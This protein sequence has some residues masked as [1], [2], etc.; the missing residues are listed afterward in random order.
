MISYLFKT[1]TNPYHLRHPEKKVDLENLSLK[2]RILG[3]SLF[4]LSGFATL[5]IL[6]A[7]Y[8][9]KAYKKITQKSST[10]TMNIQNTIFSAQKPP[11]SPHSI[12]NISRMEYESR[13]HESGVE[14]LQR[15]WIKPKRPLPSIPS[16]PNLVNLKTYKAYVH[17]YIAEYCQSASRE[18]FW[19]ELE[20][21]LRKSAAPDFD[22]ERRLKKIQNSAFH[23]Y[24]YEVLRKKYQERDT[25]TDQGDLQ[26]KAMKLHQLFIDHLQKTLPSQFPNI[27]INSDIISL[28][29][30]R[31]LKQFSNDLIKDKETLWKESLSYKAM[32]AS[33]KK[34]SEKIITD[35]QKIRDFVS[36]FLIPYI[37]GQKTEEEANR[38]TP[39]MDELI[40]F[41]NSSGYK[42]IEEERERIEEIALDAYCQI[43][44]ENLPT[45]KANKRD[46]DI[47]NIIDL[48]ANQI[49]E[50]KP[51]I[52]ILNSALSFDGF[53]VD[54][55]NIKNKANFW[56]SSSLDQLRDKII[57]ENVYR[58]MKLKGEEAELKIRSFRKSCRDLVIQKIDNKIKKMRELI[59]LK[60]VLKMAEN[61]A[62]I[63]E[64]EIQIASRKIDMAENDIG[65]EGAKKELEEA[66]MKQTKIEQTIAQIKAELKKLT[67]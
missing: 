57:Y 66:K 2:K 23:Y 20:N 52:K 26:K 48:E 27:K 46:P 62:K 45:I 24:C 39:L 64:I 56:Y 12:E 21:S 59:E 37:A 38:R 9:I 17:C 10:K 67:D 35:E 44:I 16:K 29:A 49:D 4:V 47:D 8:L 53:K 32:K 1:A 60:N 40:S 33:L 65:L 42:N 15:V 19:P 28:H 31:A 14:D 34:E 61:D 55:E 3:V 51:V 54:L 22:L 13:L 36:R 43:A 41:L 50:I 25:Q 11:A 18:P 30:E 58:K 7:Y 6:P 63:A 5:G